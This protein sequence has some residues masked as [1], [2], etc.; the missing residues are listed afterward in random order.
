[1]RRNSNIDKCIILYFS[2][3]MGNIQKEFISF[4][5]SFCCNCSVAKSCATGSQAL[6]GFCSNS[7]PLSWYSFF[8]MLC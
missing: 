5:W 2:V 4:D 7:C 6:H 1:M 3:I 8:T